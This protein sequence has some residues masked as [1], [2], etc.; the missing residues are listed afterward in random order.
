V[1][2]NF[3]FEIVRDEWDLYICESGYG[4][5]G[6]DYG[7]DFDIW[8]VLQGRY[9]LAVLFEYFATIGLIDVAY[10][11]PL[12][13]RQDYGELWGTDDLDFLSRYDGLKYIRLNNFGAFCLGFS[14]EYKSPEIEIKSSFVILPNLKIKVADGDLTV[15]ENLFLENF[16][17][18][19]SE[20]LWHLSLEQT[21]KSLEKG[22]TIS[23]LREFLEKREDQLLPETVEGF[24]RDAEKRSQAL[25]D[26]GTAKIIECESTKIADEIAKHRLTKKLCQPVGKKSLAILSQHEK[27]FR[28]NVRK[29]GYGTKYN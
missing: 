26:K 16:A 27:Q 10:I 5:L 11:D 21:I 20:K 25:T 17:E 8:L 14:D 28:T 1:R 23:N 9:I 29:I 19:E 3:D 18:K 6:Y 22:L 24:L 12:L 4:S 13:A 7:K 2:L 15:E